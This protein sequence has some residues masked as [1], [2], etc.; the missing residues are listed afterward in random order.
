MVNWV[1][2]RWRTMVVTFPVE[3]FVRVL[4][5][6]CDGLRNF[7][8]QLDNLRDVVVVFAIPRARCGIEEVIATCDEFEE[9]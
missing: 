2:L 9:L 7:T 6:K 5:R 1:R 3:E 4:A 8:K